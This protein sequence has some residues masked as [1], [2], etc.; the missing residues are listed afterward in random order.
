MGKKEIL[1]GGKQ[2]SGKKSK[3]DH[4]VFNPDQTG[5]IKVLMIEDSVTD[6]KLMQEFL[7]REKKIQF[8]LK[9]KQSLGEGLKALSEAEF[10]IILLDLNLPD[11]DDLNTVEQA[12][13]N[14]HGT[15]IIVLTGNEDDQLALASL[16]AGANDYLEKGRVNQE[17]AVR[18]IRYCLERQQL[19]KKLELAR[20]TERQQ[21]DI[22]YFQNL[23]NSATTSVTAQS[24]GALPFSQ[25]SPEIF[26]ECVE[27]YKLVIKQAM[28]QKAY[29]VDYDLTEK[30]R[31]MA[32]S[33]GFLKGGPRD[34]I[35]I[36]SKA[37][38]AKTSKASKAKQF[39]ILEEAR[40]IVL[41]LMG[42]LASFYRNYYLDYRKIGNKKK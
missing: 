38:K 11:S 9:W 21:R 42:H 25:S 8:D 30:L 27:L 29:K 33:I 13:E 26:E 34:V 32:E 17:S 31:R 40:I 35:E 41:E 23:E 15:P 12:F 5:N 4:I 3:R 2:I 14:S 24:Y 37:L 20:E 28:V 36:H 22:D 19:L 18:A 7:S 10:D 39:A 16:N 1:N 6:A